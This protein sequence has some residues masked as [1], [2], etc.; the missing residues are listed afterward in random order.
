MTG[1]NNR[2]RLADKLQYLERIS[3]LESQRSGRVA[4]R[5]GTGIVDE[6]VGYAHLQQAVYSTME[7]C[8]EEQE[9]LSS[10]EVLLPEV[11]PRNDFSCPEFKR[12]RSSTLP[13]REEDGVRVERQE[14][15]P[16]PL[17]SM[18]SIR[19]QQNNKPG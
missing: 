18:V 3:R 2:D 4:S 7:E 11:R 12:M 16:P 6:E 14:V 15:G 19:E 1:Q 9:A 13:P 5:H 10:Q 8:G 17:V